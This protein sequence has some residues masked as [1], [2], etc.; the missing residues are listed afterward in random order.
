MLPQR[1][2]DMQPGHLLLPDSGGAI[3]A[4]QQVL[5]GPPHPQLTGAHCEQSGLPAK[6]G[7]GTAMGCR[8]PFPSLCH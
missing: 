8:M 7:M 4:S 1:A 2:E 5:L 3:P 6:K